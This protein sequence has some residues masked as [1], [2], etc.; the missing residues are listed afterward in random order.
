MRVLD[1]RYFVEENI[2]LHIQRNSSLGHFLKIIIIIFIPAQRINHC[3]P[4][5]NINPI[6]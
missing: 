4:Q 6:P 2:R 1:V 3:T 5:R